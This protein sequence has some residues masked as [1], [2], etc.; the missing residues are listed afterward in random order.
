M[1][2]LVDL[3]WGP[4]VCISNMLKGMLVVLVLDHTLSRKVRGYIY[5]QLEIMPNS[6][7][8]NCVSLHS[9][10]QCMGYLCLCMC[11]SVSGLPISAA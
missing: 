8:S 5:V 3:G 11:E 7:Q 4:E 1:Q 9:Y 2:T 6:F 10:R